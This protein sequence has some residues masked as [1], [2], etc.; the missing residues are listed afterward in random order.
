MAIIYVI[1][2]SYRDILPFLICIAIVIYQIKQSIKET[3]S[4]VSIL[5]KLKLLLNYVINIIYY[6]LLMEWYLWNT[7]NRHYKLI[8]LYKDLPIRLNKTKNI[9]FDNC[10]TTIQINILLFGW[11]FRKNV[12]INFLKWY[13]KN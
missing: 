12:R 11:V 5:S 4:K 10:M 8:E 2:T 13:Y 6:N 3:E 7:F 9:L 1:E